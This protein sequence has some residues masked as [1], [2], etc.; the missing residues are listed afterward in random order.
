MPARL[1]SFMRLLRRLEILREEKR[2]P[3]VSNYRAWR[4]WPRSCRGGAAGS[5][6]WDMSLLFFLFLDLDL[7]NTQLYSSDGGLN[8]SSI[9]T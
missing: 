2:Q 3:L 1:R 5:F 7:M 8:F 9:A 6:F 4:S